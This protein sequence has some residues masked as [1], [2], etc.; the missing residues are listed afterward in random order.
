[1]LYHSLF[2]SHIRYC[3]SSWC[4]GN[5]TLID[6]L[7]RLYNKFTKIIFNL[8]L[9]ENVS[10]TISGGHSNSGVRGKNFQKLMFSKKEKEFCCL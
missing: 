4:F 3:I 10:R 9:R 7:Q 1:M 8:S 6:K 2:M 5:E